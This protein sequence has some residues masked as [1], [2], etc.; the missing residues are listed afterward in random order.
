MPRKIFHY[1][2]FFLFLSSSSI[3]FGQGS[4][5]I[6]PARKKISHLGDLSLRV[7]LGL[8]LLRFAWASAESD[9]S[10]VG[11]QQVG[12]LFALQYNYFLNDRL[13][14]I[15]TALFKLELDSILKNRLSLQ[16]TGGMRWF[17]IRYVFLDAHFLVLDIFRRSRASLAWGGFLFGGGGVISVNER[18]RLIL[19]VQI[20]LRVLFSI[21]TLVG[22]EVGASKLIRFSGFET[23]LQA[24]L[25]VEAFF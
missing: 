16:L 24:I 3:A 8:E 15:G 20:P 25:G 11:E 23:G 9:L 10:L 2:L 19:Q 1:L 6:K 5:S 12:S 14:L 17:L 21:D 7:D 13:A 22:F 4:K 18:V